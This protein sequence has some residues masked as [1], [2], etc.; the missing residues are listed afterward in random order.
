MAFLLNG[1]RTDEYYIVEVET[2]F[3][4]AV[5]NV[6]IMTVQITCFAPYQ[7]YFHA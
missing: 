4:M 1:R 6:D 2:S 7:I 5:A 3:N